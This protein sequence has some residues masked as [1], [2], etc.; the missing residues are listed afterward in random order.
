[1]SYAYI[2]LLCRK[3]KR[4]GEYDIIVILMYINV[5][6]Q[7]KIQKEKNKV[8]RLYFYSRRNL[9]PDLRSSHTHTHKRTKM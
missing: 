5:R 4:S 9:R 8:N 7:L 2:D 1:M 3:T 6:V